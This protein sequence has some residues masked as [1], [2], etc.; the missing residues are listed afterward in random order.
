MYPSEIENHKILWELIGIV[1][2]AN[3]LKE[4]VKGF[5]SEQNGEGLE[6]LGQMIKGLEGVTKELDRIANI[7]I[8]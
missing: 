2:T 8:I 4:R 3:A 7:G 1:D 5:P 6:L